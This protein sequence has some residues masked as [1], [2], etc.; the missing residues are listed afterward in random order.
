MDRNR[1]R[2]VML[3]PA[4]AASGRLPA[5]GVA[6]APVVPRA[7]DGDAQ[8]LLELCDRAAQALQRAGEPLP[9]ERWSHVQSLQEAGAIQAALAQALAILQERV[10][11]TVSVSPEARV[12][13][14]RT[15][16]R[17]RLVQGGWKVFLV[18]IDNPSLVPGRLHVDSP[19]AIPV[20]G[21][22]E[23]NDIG[24]QRQ[25]P[26]TIADVAQRWLE[27]DLLDDAQLPTLLE[28]LAADFKLLRAYSRDAGRRSASLRLDIGPGTG[29]LA[30]RD[31]TT[32]VFEAAP[33]QS[34]WLKVR[35]VDGT[36]TTCGW[37]VIDARGAVLPSQAKRTAPDLYFQRK[38]YRADGQRLLL[39]AGTYG[40]TTTRGPEYLV[41]SGERRVAAGSES[42]WEVR[43]QRWV[44]PARHGWYGGDH[45]IHAAGC[46]HYT[47][48]EEGVGPET[49]MPQALGEALAIA[50]VLTWRPGFDTQKKH[51]SG[52][53]DP[54][55]TAATRLHYD[56]EVSGFPSSHCGHLTLLQMKEMDFPGAGGIEGWPS[57]NAPVL[58]WARQQGAVTG[59][60]HAGVG[61]WAGTTE[62]P[63][64]RMPAFDGIGAND[65]IVTL[66]EGLV[67]FIST[68]NFPPAAELNIWYHTLNAGLR[69]GIAGETDWPC[70][71]EE[72]MG[73]GRS[74]VRLEGELSYGKWVEGVRARRSYVSEGR[75]HLMDFTVRSGDRKADVGGQLD[76]AAPGEVVVQASVAA[77]LEP[78][79]TTLT[80]ALRRL[81]PL[82][83]PYWHIERARLGDSRRVAVELLVNGVPAASQEIDADG[84]LRPLSFRLPMARSS[85]LALRVN[86]SAHTNPVWVLVDRRPVLVM[87]SARWCRRAVD[88]CWS[89]KSV[90]I[91]PAELAQEQALYDRARRYYEARAEEASRRS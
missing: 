10:L 5:H 1:R 66:P 64:D 11:L 60:G 72:S 71:F 53:D 16:Q 90:R 65:Y 87:E 61:L 34:V 84:E 17:P 24:I 85:W 25:A 26:T 44:D 51:F 36:P 33:A 62:L 70:F 50:G 46:A 49:L 19:Q 14:R 48:P 63:N 9:A 86:N 13:V 79:P 22:L 15:M 83:K 28:P 54:L 7:S 68:C 29:D 35:D 8:A 42:A 88:Q 52:R 80:E 31:R 4:A 32:V 77:R 37:E 2:L 76:L 91:R 23:K 67:D 3:V 81:G 89:Q 74:Y 38:V 39:P 21:V 30:A 78:V 18:R 45:H 47:L 57:T 56:L 40:V 20:H 73:M 43:L 75:T 12:G 82:D 59:Y 55:S 27:I 41:Q 58:R 69:A 6:E